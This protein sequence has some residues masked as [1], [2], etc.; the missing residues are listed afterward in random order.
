M[1][2]RDSKSSRTNERFFGSAIQNFY[3]DAWIIPV[4]A[5]RLQTESQMLVSALANPFISPRTSAGMAAFLSACFSSQYNI[6]G[7]SDYQ[8]SIA[9]DFSIL[10][11]TRYAE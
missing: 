7:N 4:M 2:E 9:S 1:S 3:F 10:G 11:W 6:T 8:D 5:E